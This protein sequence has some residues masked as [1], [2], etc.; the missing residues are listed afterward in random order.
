MRIVVIGS[1]GVGKSCIVVRFVNGIFVKTYEPTIED[2]YRKQIDVENETVMLD[3]LDTAGHDEFSAL[4]DSYMKTG[5]GFIIVYA[6]NSA[7][8]FYDCT[9][10]YT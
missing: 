5:D 9:K 3:I 1:G 4:R 7:S 8:S 6:I 10:L 2:F